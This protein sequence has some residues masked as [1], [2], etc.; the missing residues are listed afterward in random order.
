[1]KKY[2]LCLAVALSV[3]GLFFTTPVFADDEVRNLTLDLKGK[4]FTQ[5]TWMDNLDSSNIIFGPADKFQLQLT[6]SNKGNR[7]Q[8]N[9]KVKQTL[10]STVTT[11][12]YPE[13]IINQIAAGQDFVQ[14]ITVTVK[15]KAAILA[16]LTK[17]T[18]RYD[19][20]ST[21][22]GSQAGDYL[23]FY[24]NNGTKSTA[25]ATSS[26]LPA[27]GA[28][29]NILLGSGIALGVGLAAFALRKMARG[30]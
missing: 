18:I 4:G 12:Y 14:N 27:T 3:G 28:A 21:D 7:N 1:M 23:S 6:I 13:T 30:Y 5:S 8:T 24:T 19:I 22:V 11:D 15:N 10:P 25:V 17:S 26:G 16:A 29:S 9:I 20:T 2:L